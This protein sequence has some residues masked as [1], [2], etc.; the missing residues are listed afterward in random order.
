[1]GAGGESG[2]EDDDLLGQEAVPASTGRRIVTAVGLVALVV[3]AVVGSNVF[4]VRDGLLG[5]ATPAPTAA[6]L[7]RAADSPAGPT[8]VPGLTR[9]RS[10]PW[11]Q[12]VTTLE[13]AGPT[14]TTPFLV[15]ANAIQWR[16]KWSCGSGRLLV[17]AAQSKGPLVDGACPGGSWGFATKTGSVTMQVAADGPWKLEVEQ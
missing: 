13:G 9:L 17:Q 15:G 10:Q 4:G 12:A 5:S 14:T 6:A 11:W 2:R 7:S 8:T 3:S 16:V 1:M